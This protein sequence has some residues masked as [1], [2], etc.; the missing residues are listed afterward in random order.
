MPDGSVRSQKNAPFDQPLCWLWGQAWLLGDRARDPAC[1]SVLGV[2]LN[3]G[4]FPI[5]LLEG[6]FG[7][8]WPQVKECLGPPGA[9]RIL[10][11]IL[12]RELTLPTPW[13]WTFGLQTVGEYMFADLSHPVWVICYGSP[14]KL[15]W[16]DINVS[17]CVWVLNCSRLVH[18]FVTLWIVARQAP[19]STEFSR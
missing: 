5:L 3:S 12:P 2:D 9:G 6:Q 7:R 10:P 8:M 18:L 1:G 11:W 13:F 19:L 4:I 15:I 16:H 14:R 17:I